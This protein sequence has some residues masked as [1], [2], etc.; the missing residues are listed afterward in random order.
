MQQND[1]QISWE[2]PENDATCWDRRKVQCLSP[3]SRSP[4]LALL[5]S[6]VAAPAV[7]S[8]TFSSIDHLTHKPG[9]NTIR[10]A[11]QTRDSGM[12]QIFRKARLCLPAQVLHST[13][14]ESDLGWNWHEPEQGF[15]GERI[16]REGPDCAI[17]PHPEFCRNQHHSFHALLSRYMEKLQ[18]AEKQVA[19]SPLQFRKKLTSSSHDL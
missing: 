11:G 6:K 3:P 14:C 10:T 5:S 2:W 12:F 18:L 19:F 7:S 13:A 17:H 1:S 16:S 9:L 4:D 15:H 8:R